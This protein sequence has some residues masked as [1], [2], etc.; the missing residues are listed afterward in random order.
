MMEGA[1]KEILN[2]VACF[3]LQNT[4]WI[5]S[6]RNHGVADLEIQKAYHHFGLTKQTLWIHGQ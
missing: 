6:S 5:Q 3:D 1:F 4:P 2:Y